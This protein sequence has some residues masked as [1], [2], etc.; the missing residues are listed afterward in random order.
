MAPGQWVATD[1][2]SD[3]PEPS[4]YVLAHKPM[5]STAPFGRT[6]VNRFVRDITDD[7]IRCLWHMQVSAAYYSVPKLL[8]LNLT[9]RQYDEMMAAGKDKY[10]LDRVLLGEQ[11]PDGTTAQVSQLSGNSPQPFIDEL[12]ALAK[13]FAGITSVPLNS[14]GIVQDNPSSAD[15]IQA[16]REDICLVAEQDIA[17]DREVLRRVAMAAMAQAGNVTIDE[18]TEHQRGVMASFEEP[19]LH[20]RSE[21]ADW[22][23]KV[24]SMRPGF[25]ETDVAAEMVGIR[26]AELPRMKADERRAASQAASQAIFGGS[27]GSG[28]A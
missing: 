7:A 19:M 12:M 13:Q 6:R 22:A 27:L 25:G 10:Q 8:M 28:T 21:M 4:L 3:E 24:S 23:V 26:K 5:G 2:P 16:A 11:N 1:G 15:A 20:S 17:E 9:S 18:L 14:L